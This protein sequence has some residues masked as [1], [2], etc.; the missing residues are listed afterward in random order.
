M[1]ITYNFKNLQKISWFPGHMHRG[2]RLLSSN[3]QK[4]DI[5]LEIRDARLPLSSFNK[6][7]D[8]YL[9]KHNKEK[10][11]LFNK[12]DLCE[13]EK[14]NEIIKELQSLG[15]ITMAVS[16]KE[17][18]YDFSNILKFSKL[19]KTEKYK[20]VGIWM[21][22]GGIP[23]VG[24]SNII[25]NLRVLSKSYKNNKVT[26][27][28]NK[29]CVTT[30]TNGFK[31]CNDPLVHLLDSPGILSP[32][33]ENT[34]IGLNLSIIGSLKPKIASKFVLVDY[35]FYK[36][37]ERG[38]D[39]VFKKYNLSRRP[40]SSEDLVVRLCEKFGYQDEGSAYDRVLNDFQKGL[41]GKYTLDNVYQKLEL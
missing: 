4:I 22:A 14:T 33:I 32:N 24:K 5:F 26:K 27:T 39:I 31:I 20:T 41:L 21:M 17:R 2:L 28:Y 34:E 23:N 16:S 18:R 15:Y 3:L 11:I 6:S 36:I 19:V 40:D 10:I 13:K 1:S 30:Y 9:K 25:N 8:D 35:L 29:P 37:G 7:I 38:R 12:Y